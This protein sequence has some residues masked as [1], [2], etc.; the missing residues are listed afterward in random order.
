M[1]SQNG[2]DNNVNRLS[3]S[4]GHLGELPVTHGADEYR[5]LSLH[6]FTEHNSNKFNKG[7]TRDT[8]R[9]SYGEKRKLFDCY[10]Q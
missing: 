6:L 9:K 4:P 10:L 2:V 8:S 5:Y 3:I 1:S 7:E